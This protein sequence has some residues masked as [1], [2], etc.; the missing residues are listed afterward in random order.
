M[1]LSSF[2]NPLSEISNL[3][4]IQT[5]SIYSLILFQEQTLLHLALK[6]LASSENSLK[7]ELDH[8]YDMDSNKAEFESQYLE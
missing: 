8:T 3:I 4:I 1:A 2:T 6:I 5:G 7:D